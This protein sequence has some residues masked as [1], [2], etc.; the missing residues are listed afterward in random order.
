[1]VAMNLVAAKSRRC[2]LNVAPAGCGKSTATNIVF[3]LLKPRVARY[4]S[5][6]LAGLHFLQGEL[7]NFEGTIVIDDLGAEKSTWSRVATVSTL[8]HLTYSHEVSKYTQSLQL[9]IDNF[10]GSVAFNVQPV[11]MQSLLESDDWVAVIRDKIIRYYHLVRPIKPQINLPECE[12]DWGVDYTAVKIGEF[13]GKW[14]WKLFQQGLLEWSAARC[15]EHIPAM[16][17]S[18]AALD[19]RTKV[20]LSD[21]VILSRLMKNFT[22]ERHMVETYGFESARQFLQNAYY[23]LVEMASF[24]HLTHEQIAVDYKVS[25]RTVER[26]L[27]NV[28]DYCFVKQNEHKRIEQT[29]YA[30]YILEAS[31]VYDKW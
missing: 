18:C 22:L 5:I 30:K 24:P 16:L 19:G 14:Y 26:L 28:I 9:K 11:L 7:K 4:G 2:I 21:Y 3:N 8:A 10:N 15:N 31:G 25:V 12:I 13:K 17:K 27:G 1:M 6:T 23:M 29:D 20:Q